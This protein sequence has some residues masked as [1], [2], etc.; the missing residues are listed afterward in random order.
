MLSHYDDSDVDKDFVPPHED[1]GEEDGVEQSDDSENDEM[2]ES[3]DEAQESDISEHE[4]VNESV[5]DGN[6]VQWKNVTNNFV[7]IFQIPPKEDGTVLCD[8]SRD[9]TPLQIFRKLVPRSLTNYIAQCTNERIEKDTKRGKCKM[10][11]TDGGEILVGALGCSL[12]MGL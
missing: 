8:L 4:L 10:E 11:K 1:V 12:V 2:K 3:D 6:A 9:A 7:P 5:N